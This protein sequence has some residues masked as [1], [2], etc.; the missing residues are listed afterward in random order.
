[1]GWFDVDKEGLAKQLE[2]KDKSFILNELLQNSWDTNATEV[3]VTLTPIPNKPF[4]TIEVRDDDPEGFTNLSHA[5]T[6]FAESEKK[7]NPEKRGRFNLGEKLVLALCRE[8]EIRTT[9]GMVRFDDEGRTSSNQAASRLERGSIFK[10]T[11]RMKREEYEQVCLAA[12]RVIPPAGKK[13]TFNGEELE[14]RDQ[15]DAFVTVLPTEISDGENVMRLT[16]RKTLVTLCG[17]FEGEVPTLYEMGIPV[18]ELDGG[19]PWHVNIA[20]KV[21]LNS[22]RDNVTPAYLRTLRTA[23][24][25]EMH[26]HLEDVDAASQEWVREAAASPDASKEAVEHVKVQRFGVMAVANDPSDPEGSKLAMQ[27]GYTVIPGGALSKGE[28]DNLKKHKIVLPAGQVTPSTPGGFADT[29]WIDTE[30][31]TAGMKALAK[32]VQRM[33][34]VLIDRKISVFFV[35]S[36]EAST[37]AQWG[38]GK[39]TFNVITLGKKF[40]E[41]GVTEK[42]V[43]LILHELGHHLSGDHLSKEYNDALTRLGA[44]LAFFTAANPTFFKDCDW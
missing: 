31:Q 39:M 6:L 17:V 34:E 43:D 40:F 11:L 36:P 14:A 27:E 23:M 15:K 28:W 25:N 7:G 18:V 33:G 37:L 5:F 24:L 41:K 19:E 20:Q 12:R 26:A 38:H 9:K 8:A 42:Q 13:T 2:G 10:A 1:M 32:L 21:P 22:N 44:K 3:V 35:H 4:C 16:K 30:K 29:S